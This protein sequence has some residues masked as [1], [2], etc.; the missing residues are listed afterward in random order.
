M[1]YGQRV[2]T[3]LCSSLGL[4]QGLAHG[5]NLLHWQHLLHGGPSPLP[6]PLP[7]LQAAARA[8][9]E[10]GSRRV[11]GIVPSQKHVRINVGCITFGDRHGV[12]STVLG[13]AM[14]VVVVLVLEDFVVVRLAPTPP[15]STGRDAGVRNHVV[16]ARLVVAKEVF[17]ATEYHKVFRI[18]KVLRAVVV[19]QG[20]VARAR[21][22]NCSALHVCKDLLSRSG[23]GTLSTLQALVATAAAAAAAPAPAAPVAAGQPRTCSRHAKEGRAHRKRRQQG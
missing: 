9:A 15:C 14:V 20:P 10:D 13:K 7:C 2:R 17:A 16:I 4:Q 19:I 3:L 11:Q 1:E 18:V 6:S 21:G 12:K 23:P 22:R 8:V 5:N